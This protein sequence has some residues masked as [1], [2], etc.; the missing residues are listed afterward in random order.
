MVPMFYDYATI[1]TKKLL[2]K[3]YR[4]TLQVIATIF[5]PYCNNLLSRRLLIY[6]M[7][8]SEGD[9]QLNY[10]KMW[11]QKSQNNF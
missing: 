6:S 2:V 4:Y 10:I 3:T 5:K 9:K 7:R 1:C 11:T 8:H